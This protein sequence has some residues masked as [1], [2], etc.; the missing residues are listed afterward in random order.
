MTNLTK[1]AVREDLIRLY[2]RLTGLLRLLPSPRLGGLKFFAL[3]WIR[4]HRCSSVVKTFA[5]AARTW[6]FE[7]Y[8]RTFGRSHL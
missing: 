2:V 4:V 7:C 1:S 5:D 3:N 8:Q 6:R